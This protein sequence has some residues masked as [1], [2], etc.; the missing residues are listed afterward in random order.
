[1]RFSRRL[2]A[3]ISVVVIF[4]FI[5]SIC[6]VGSAGSSKLVK[7]LKPTPEAKKPITLT[8]YSAETNPND[9]GFK[10]PVAQKI[11]ELTGV[12]LKIEYA[13]AQGAG[14]QKLQ[15]MAASGDYPD[16]VYAKG[17]LQLLKNAGGIVQLDS[18]IEKYGPNIKK[19]YGKNLKRLR[20]SPQDPHIYCLGITTDNDA[21]LDVNGGFMIQHRVVIEQK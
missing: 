4:S 7:P 10:S 20:W 2:F 15:L 14:Q 8:M 13:I 21:T 18:L 17:D 16:L 5:L 11:K 12:T 1:M 6:L 9:D 3:V 19:A